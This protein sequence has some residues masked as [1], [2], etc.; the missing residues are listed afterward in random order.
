VDDLEDYAEIFA[1]AIAEFKLNRWSNLAYSGRTAESQLGSPTQLCQVNLCNNVAP[2]SSCGDCI[3]GA[4]KFI[5]VYSD[6]TQSADYQNGLGLRY[7]QCAA[8]RNNDPTKCVAK[9]WG[10]ELVGCGG[11]LMQYAQ[12]LTPNPGV[13]CLNDVSP[14]PLDLACSSGQP[15]PTPAILFSGYAGKVNVRTKITAVQL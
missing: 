3:I 14:L 2:S 4:A 7:P 6:G 13:T 15:A 8:F 5:F 11:H 9:V 10:T 1:E 12:W